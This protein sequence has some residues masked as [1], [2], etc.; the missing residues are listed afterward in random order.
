MFLGSSS[1]RGPS[2]PPSRP[3]SQPG[4]RAGSVSRD[5]Q[6]KGR[7]PAANLVRRTQHG[8]ATA[9]GSLGRRSRPKSTNLSPCRN[10]SS[11]DLISPPTV[12]RRTPRI[13][14]KSPSSSD[15]PGNSKSLPRQVAHQGKLTLRSVLDKSNNV[16][17]RNSGKW[18]KPP[19]PGPMSP[20]TSDS[21]NNGLHFSQPN[22]CYSSLPKNRRQKQSKEPS[23]QD[24]HF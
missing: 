14:S 5:V 23:P 6:S 9:A 16:P 15:G 18:S 7:S 3:G 17:K 2:R 12:M 1:H 22:S 13:G 4:S 8:A 19:T 11:R 21:D 24:S 10:L 20:A